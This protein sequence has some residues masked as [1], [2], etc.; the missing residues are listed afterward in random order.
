[1]N[2]THLKMVTILSWTSV[3]FWMAIIFWFSDQPATASNQLSTGIIDQLFHIF[4][5]AK[6][7]FGSLYNTLNFIIRK[8]AHFFVYLVL[9]ILI[10]NAF[11]VSDIRFDHAK[12]M[13]IILGIMYAA[14]DEFHQ[15]YVIGRSGQL[16][17]VLI[18]SLGVLCGI[19]IY[20]YLMK[21]K[22]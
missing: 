20:C 18:D 5:I 2:K 11:F 21:R 17:D 15:I 6:A 12:L 19:Y 16:T 14:S 7:D 3:I 9:G 1:M 4:N 10:I 13:S 8:Q 22:S